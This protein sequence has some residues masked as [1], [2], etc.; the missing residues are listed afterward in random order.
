M[1][2][3]ILAHWKLDVS[4]MKGVEDS[5]SSTVYQCTLASGQQV[6]VKIPFSKVKFDRE[7][8]TY[9]LLQG[10]VPIPKL[11]DVWNGN[12]DSPGAFL[13][14]KVDGDPLSMSVDPGLAYQVG[15]LHASL[16][17]VTP[18]AN[19]TIDNEFD[20]WAEFVD[21]KFYLF[22]EAVVK[23]LDEQTYRQSITLFE[24]WKKEL[25]TPDGP[26]F[27]HMDFRPANILV[28]GDVVTGVIDFESVRFGSTEVDFT[29]I[30]RDFLSLDPVNMKEFRNGY[31]SVRPM[32]DLDV[33][34]PFYQFTDAFNSMGWCVQR[35]L[36]RHRGF[37]EQ[38]EGI[39]RRFLAK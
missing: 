5:H 18:R 1:I 27:L 24:E 29:K 31:E 2:Q 11:L 26:A 32:I 10:R 25:P 14:S 15:A 20:K 23:E 19:E 35:G 21:E 13:L 8:E 17:S 6:F 7:L 4:D 37:Y 36:E 38:N 3:H 33:V 34:L 12:D 30:H 9:Q 16:H 28:N 22:A 39:L